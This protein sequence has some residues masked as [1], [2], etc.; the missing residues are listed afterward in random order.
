MHELVQTGA[1]TSH[2]L[3]PQARGRRYFIAGKSVLALTRHDQALKCM[4]TVTLFPLRSTRVSTGE[5]SAL[6][7]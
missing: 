2:E 4:Q 7:A 5:Y 6:G 3:G 1:G